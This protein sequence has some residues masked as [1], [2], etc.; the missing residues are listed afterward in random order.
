MHGF[1]LEFIPY[2]IRG[3]NDL[4]NN[5]VYNVINAV[6]IKVKGGREMSGKKK[7]CRSLKI[8]GT[9]K[10][11]FEDEVLEAIWE[12]AE[13][14]EVHFT[15][16]INEIGHEKEVLEMQEDGL[17]IIKEDKIYF[18]EKGRYR[19]RDIT[20]RHL[21]AER[22][23]ADVLALKDYEDDACLFEHVI[24]PEVEEAICTFLG[25]PPTCPHGRT[26]P[27]GN[28]CRVY[29]RE[30]KPLVQ[31]LAY[32]EVGTTAKVV[33][34]ATPAMEKLTAI[35]LVPGETVKLQQKRPS[36]VIGIGETT[37]AIDEEI[38]KKIYVKQ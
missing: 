28:C 22:L 10:S 38:A 33:F 27:K 29:T 30:V 14:E 2:L 5:K 13:D 17:I 32:I 31:P 15:D 8:S 37:V 36:Y 21:L 19:A 25:H 7:L 16:L 34:I 1:L 4:K 9:E 23:F 3:R 6:T 20:R 18:T 35:G 12:L 26:I 24:S 11:M